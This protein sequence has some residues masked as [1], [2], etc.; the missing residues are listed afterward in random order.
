MPR[1]RRQNVT[2]AQF[3]T[4]KTN[5][6]SPPM[7]TTNCAVPPTT[8][9]AVTRARPAAI[10]GRDALAT[11]RPERRL[12][13]S[14]TGDAHHRV[15][16]V[17]QPAGW[18][19]SERRRWRPFREHPPW[20]R[21]HHTMRQGRREG[22]GVPDVRTER[23]Q[24]QRIPPPTPRVRGEHSIAAPSPHHRTRSSAW[25]LPGGATPC[26]P[27]TYLSGSSS[28]EPWLSWSG[29]DRWPPQSSRPCWRFRCSIP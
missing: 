16:A 23:R 2:T 29:R 24:D 12:M 19:R 28:S 26:G 21:Q 15:A 11:A 9:P 25:P 13:P 27:T 8:S 10:I 5:V 18:P 3:P 7:A 20:L 1:R 6:A 14:L 17:R 22:R 4:P